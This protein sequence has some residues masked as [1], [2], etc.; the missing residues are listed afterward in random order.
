MTQWFDKKLT[1][2]SDGDDQSLAALQ[3]EYP[4]AICKS[5]EGI[6]AILKKN[7][8]PYG[9]GG[10]VLT[11]SP[12]K[13]LVCLESDQKLNDCQDYLVRFCCKG[14]KKLIN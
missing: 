9:K 4:D 14:K 11:I 13:G 1:T 12:T 10:N 3:A 2:E 5:P 8:D 7:G 6:Q